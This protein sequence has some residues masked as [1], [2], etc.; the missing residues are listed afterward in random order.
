MSESFFQT[1]P[2]FLAMALSSLMAPAIASERSAVLI[3][4][5]TY[6]GQ[7]AMLGIMPTRF[8]ATGTFK[9]TQVTAMCPEATK[10]VKSYEGMF[11]SHVDKIEP[12][13]PHR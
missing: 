11:L 4:D 7:A 10:Y 6:E 8:E 2:I 5:K 1:G 3:A 13:R 9:T 12:S